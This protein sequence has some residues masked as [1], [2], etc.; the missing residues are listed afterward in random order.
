MAV[1]GETGEEEDEGGEK[2]NAKG[3][4]GTSEDSEEKPAAQSTLEDKDAVGISEASEASD[5]DKMQTLVCY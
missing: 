1:K 2:E 5:L 4:K 3:E